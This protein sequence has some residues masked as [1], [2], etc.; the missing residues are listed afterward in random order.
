MMTLIAK[1]VRQHRGIIS[2]SVLLAMVIPWL[3][4][5]TGLEYGIHRSTQ[6]LSAF[7]FGWSMIMPGFA[8]AS[9]AEWLMSAERTKRTFLILRM[10]PKSSSRVIA[11]KELTAAAYLVVVYLLSFASFVCAFRILVRIPPILPR[12]TLLF[13]GFLLLISLAQGSLWLRLKVQ[14]KWAAQ[15]PVFLGLL[16]L[17]SGMFAEG[18]P[19]VGWH[20]PALFL[21]CCVSVACVACVLAF[22]VAMVYEFDRQDWAMPASE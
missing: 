17:S 1:D 20:L 11:A 18:L 14:S 8:P 6:E 5:W 15:V 9:V 7:A 19:S 3:Q 13:A 10:L 16:M 21:W 2:A 12:A 22:H 4:V